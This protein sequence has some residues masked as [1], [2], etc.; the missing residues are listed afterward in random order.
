MFNTRFTILISILISFTTLS[1]T[2][3]YDLEIHNSPTNT[4]VA[5]NE[6]Q[7]SDATTVKVKIETF[8]GSDF[9]IVWDDDTTVNVNSLEEISHTYEVPY[10]G[11][12]RFEELDGMQIKSIEISGGFAFDIQQ[13][14]SFAPK[15]E[16]LITNKDIQCYGD[17]ANKPTSL[18]YIDLQVG[19]FYGHFD[20]DRL[21]NV[22]RLRIVKGNTVSFNIADF[23]NTIKYIGVT[24]MNTATGS[25]DSLHYPLLYHFDI[26]GKNSISGDLGKMNTPRLSVFYLGGNS[27]ASSYT[28]GSLNIS[29]YPQ[30]FI[31]G[32]PLNA[33]ST[34]DIDALLIDLDNVSTSWSGA[35]L[36]ILTTAHSPPSIDSST[37]RSSL[38]MKGAKVFTN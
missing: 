21:R 2:H 19:N 10:S 18:I 20:K 37:A 27:T 11:K 1:C 31:Y 29:S 16:S 12:I 33:L 25:L 9:S 7:M 38:E 5:P 22:K 17:V 36:L 15:I 23:D 34:A 8:D 3:N 30:I 26:K 6:F 32:G 28:A 13:L 24:G 35:K 4:I 14:Y